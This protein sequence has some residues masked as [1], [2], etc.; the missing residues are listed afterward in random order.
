MIPTHIPFSPLIFFFPAPSSS[1]LFFPSFSF[2]LL[3][4]F[5]SLPFPQISLCLASR[6]LLTT[7]TRISFKP[8][9]PRYHQTEVYRF[10]RSAIYEH[11]LFKKEI[12]NP[13]YEHKISGLHAATR[14]SRKHQYLENWY[15][16][17]LPKLYF[18]KKG[19]RRTVELWHGSEKKYII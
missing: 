1:P 6:T 2:L 9:N 4:F 13:I 10:A 15:I 18:T 5:L 8:F 19:V 7:Q 3:L 16:F 14:S 11:K 17:Q 12:N